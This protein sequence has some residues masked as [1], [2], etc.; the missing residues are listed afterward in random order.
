MIEKATQAKSQSGPGNRKA[1][2]VYNLTKKYRVYNKPADMFWELVTRRPKHKD[3]WA[4]RDVSFEVARGEVIGIIG[5]NGAGKSTLLKILTG[6]LDKSGGEVKI[7]GKI[8]AILELGTGFHPEY[9]G[10]EN[11]YMGGMCLG[12]TRGEVDRRLDSIIDFSELREVIDQPFKTY[13]S[14]M[15]GRLTFAVAISVEPDIFIVDEALATGDA[16]FVQK[17][18]RRL[19]AICQSGSTVLLVSHGTALLAQ[20]CH[21]VIWIDQ[22]VIK[23]IGKPLQ[24]IRAYDL[25]MHALNSGGKG[26]VHEVP[27]REGAVHDGAAGDALKH[28]IAGAPPKEVLTGA[29][30]QTRTIYKRG[31][32]F[33]DKV[34]TLNGKGE[35][36]ALL[37]PSDRL[38]IRIHYHCEGPPPTETLGMALSLNCK[39][40]L[41][42]VSQAYTQNLR[43]GETP[44]SYVTAPYRRRAGPKGIFEA[45]LS[46]LQLRPG[47]YLLSVGLVPNVPCN[48]EFY[49][50]HHFGYELTVVSDGDDF[51]ALTYAN[52]KWEHLTSSAESQAGE[53]ETATATLSP[54]AA[55]APALA[56]IESPYR[57][58]REEIHDIC[59]VRGGY[60]DRWRRHDECP[61]CGSGRLRES[62]QK[63][64]LAHSECRRCHLIF[65]NP[66]PSED[67]LHQLYNGSYYTGVRRFVE[68]PKALADM[69][70]SSISVQLDHVR[71][72]LRHLTKK[73]RTGSWLDVGGGIGGFAHYLQTNYP[74][75]QVFLNE[76][77]QES[78]SFARRH[79]QLRVLDTDFKE[80]ARR[81]RSFDIISVIAVLEH[82]SHPRTFLEDLLALL[83]P[84]GFLFLYVPNFS[85]LNRMVSRASSPAVCPPYHLS[86]FN[87]RA[88]LT[89]LRSLKA[90]DRV[91]SWM[92]GPP[93]FSLLH[94]FDY[95][96]HWDLEVPDA[97]KAV[98]KNLQIKPYTSAEA[99]MLNHLAE[100]DN[101]LGR[102][103]ERRDGKMCISVIARKRLA[104]TTALPGQ[105]EAA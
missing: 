50:Y 3:F 102:L 80:L 70:D 91:K 25:T 18:L 43:P 37:A 14:G 6:T 42:G 53:P 99:H 73:Q 92:E 97:P 35:E 75:Y 65:V 38:T 36:T 33:I 24:V 74:Q 95:S 46:P 11:I 12:M 105:G 7:D 31:P 48:W 84:G 67:V 100:G 101:L 55:P 62:F 85:P 104:V 71:R 72:A 45:T 61:A 96:D 82:V 93:A 98:V 19:R 16:A 9:S 29:V 47:E 17:C 77:N 81:G 59:F 57:T 78:A 27:I 1:I 15:K 39:D 30:A 8:S 41:F 64:Q 32:I 87:T 54:M 60:P 89:M 94:F 56:H 51:G 52:V 4:L 103:I 28:A 66:Y 44:A 21:R 88:L 83:R 5:R 86:L 2:Q 40:D 49:E 58:L 13:S 20:L 26:S 10:R 34:Q 76:L 68:E 69:A 90:C 79:F 23:Q 22:G 63:Y